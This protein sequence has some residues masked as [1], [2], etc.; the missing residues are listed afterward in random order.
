MIIN[1]FLNIP[2][3]I[4]GLP[5]IETGNLIYQT[6]EQQ[7]LRTQFWHLYYRS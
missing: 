5:S 3:S 4:Y 2:Q 6:L 1:N 7:G